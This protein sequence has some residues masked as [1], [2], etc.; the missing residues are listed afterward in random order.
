MPIY[1]QLG[2]VQG[3]STDVGHERW[4]P[5]TSCMVGKLDIAASAATGARNPDIKQLR[6]VTRTRYVDG[7]STKLFQMANNGSQ[8]LVAVLDFSDDHGDT[9]FSLKL[10]EAQ[11]SAFGVSGNRQ[12]ATSKPMESF[13]LNFTKLEIVVQNTCKAPPSVPM[14]AGAGQP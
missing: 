10:S 4:I 1:L 2:Q 5:I 6:E 3:L 13:T 11:V 12:G 7:T 8:P 9:Y 14:S